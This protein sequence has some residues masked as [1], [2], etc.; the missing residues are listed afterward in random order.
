MQIYLEEP[1]SWGVCEIV[2]M[3]ISEQLQKMVENTDAEGWISFKKPANLNSWWDVNL[4][5]TAF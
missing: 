1:Q 2:S 3:Y 5:L 4:Y